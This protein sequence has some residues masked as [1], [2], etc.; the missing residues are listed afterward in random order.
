[1]L[2]FDMEIQNNFLS[3]CALTSNLPIPLL[4]F[5][6]QGCWLESCFHWVLLAHSLENS[7]QLAN[8]MLP[9]VTSLYEPPIQFPKWPQRILVPACKRAGG[10]AEQVTSDY[11][12]Q[13]RSWH[14][15]KWLTT[16]SARILNI[17][18]PKGNQ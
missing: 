7:T 15:N 1:M 18:S 2:N 10:G 4:V 9:M 13:G 16:T 14:M 3:N 11:R 12:E 8:I 6:F 17:K 5:V